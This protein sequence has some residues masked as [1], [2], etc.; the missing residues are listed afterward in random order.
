M[1][2]LKDESG[3]ALVMLAGS[4]IVLLGLVG[5]ATDV[6]ILLR[7]Q[8]IMQTAADAAAVGAASEAL[9][10]R[11]A[12]GVSNAMCASAVIDAQLASNDPGALNYYN[13]G[14]ATGGASNC[15]GASGTTM[16]VSSSDGS[17][18]TLNVRGSI[19][20][21]GYSTGGNVQAIASKPSS[22]VFMAAVGALFGNSFKNI[23]VSTTAIASDT[24]AS[25]GCFWAVDDGQLVTSGNTLDM[26]GHSLIT[27]PGNTTTC[28]VTVNGNIVNGGSSTINADFVV[29]SG[30]VP[31]GNGWTGN[32]G[33]TQP[34]PMSYLQTTVPTA[35]GGAC[36][37]P[38]NAGLDPKMVCLYDQNGDGTSCA[39]STT[40]SLSGTL[41]DN[42]VYYY[43]KPVNMGNGASVS[44][45]GAHGDM[46]Y[47]AGTNP[48]PYIDFMNGGMNIDPP[49]PYPSSAVDCKDPTNTNPFCGVLID[50]PQDGSDDKGTYTCSPGHG[51]N[52]SNPGAVYLDF[53][54]STANLYGVLYA[55]YMQLF[56]QDQGASAN[57]FT[58][59]VIGNYCGQSATLTLS[60]L[61]ASQ[62]P[63]T[64]VGLVY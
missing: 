2:K 57:L 28:G 29:A 62:S 54:S 36:T 38:T 48:D 19:G 58:D 4:M 44:G 21:S 10:E 27:G 7:E 32:T 24:I 11:N 51:S 8:R 37:L 55:P 30:T 64:R 26:A 13:P 56:V 61:S 5:F 35:S 15:T 1:R 20:I 6:G 14:D 17:T 31:S 33:V 60:A 43:D 50:A 40:C 52:A 46:I 45:T 42:A 34:D 47:L 22:T 3:Q 9:N 49:V 18:L 39:T 23:T 25:N 53:G 41:T 16:T 59:V 12:T 63:I